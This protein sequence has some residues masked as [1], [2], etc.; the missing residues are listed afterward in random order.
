MNN[1][2]DDILPLSEIDLND[3]LYFESY[4][5]DIFC[6]MKSGKIRVKEKLYT[7]TELFMNNGIIRIHNSYLVN[8]TKI[9]DISPQ[10]NSTLKLTLVNGDKIYVSRTY[11]KKFRNYLK[12]GGVING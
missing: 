8:T 2:H 9:K 6:I 5:D 12:N 3:I 1:T 10:F 4:D 11:L 7:L